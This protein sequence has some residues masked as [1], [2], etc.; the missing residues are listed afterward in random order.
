[1]ACGGFDLLHLGHIRFLEAA[2]AL[3]D[4]LI[5]SCDSDE[6]L[7]RRKPGRPIVP[8][9][10]RREMLYALRCVDCVLSHDAD[11][12]AALVRAIAPDVL[13]K[14]EEYRDT[15]IPGERYAG[16]VVFLPRLE[17]WSTTGLLQGVTNGD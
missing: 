3:G 6:N 9:E 12:E 7:A 10:L 11:S 15:E 1:M 16:R 8:L 17:R 14:G 13:V 2:K 4:V 5:V